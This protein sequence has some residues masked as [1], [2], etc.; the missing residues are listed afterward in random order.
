MERLN[1]TKKGYRYL[2]FT[3]SIEDKERFKPHTRGVQM[4]VV[5]NFYSGQGNM[6]TTKKCVQM[7][8]VYS[9]YVI[10]CQRSET[11]VVQHPAVWS[12]H[13][14]RSNQC[15]YRWVLESLLLTG[16]M[17][18]PSLFEWLVGS[19]IPYLACIV[20]TF[21]NFQH[22]MIWM[23][24]Q[25]FFQN[26]K[27]KTSKVWFHYACTSMDANFI[28]TPSTKCTALGAFLLMDMFG[29][30]NFHASLW[31]MTTCMTPTS[32]RKSTRQLPKCS[33]GLSR[34]LPQ[35]SGHRQDP[36]ERSSLGFAKLEL[37]HA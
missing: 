6:W 36:L 18:K 5:Y 22:A 21:L 11:H 30:Q 35:A 26:G 16:G 10:G 20:P 31:G 14:W 13:D 8:T 1:H 28:P 27:I 17:A 24:T 34:L 19:K 3:I 4:F 15:C 29:I 9:F 25:P 32:K 37:V 12:V 7:F 2:L 33:P 23:N